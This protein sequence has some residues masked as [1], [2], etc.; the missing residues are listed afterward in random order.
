MLK[1]QEWLWLQL[2]RSIAFVFT[3][4]PEKIQWQQFLFIEK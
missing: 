3:K 2:P 1:T 4:D